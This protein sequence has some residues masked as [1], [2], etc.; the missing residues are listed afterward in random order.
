L[1]AI[2]ADDSALA[3]L[4]Q[5]DLIP[6]S[7]I[8]HLG[9]VPNEYCYYYYL[10]DQALERQLAARETRGQLLARLDGQL[11]QDLA[12]AGP[13]DADQLVACYGQY[14]KAREESYLAAERQTPRRLPE[15]SLRELILSGGQGYMEV[16]FKIIAGLGGLGNERAVLNVSNS[17]GVIPGMKEDDIVETMC[18]ITPDG[19]LPLPGP[20]LL[21]ES[22]ALLQ[23]VKAYERL[24][25]DAARTGS[26]WLAIRAL[27]H[28][29][30][31]A[32]YP[33]AE[34]LVDAYLLEHRAFLPQFWREGP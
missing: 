21:P 16:A 5:D 7:L 11:E 32:S 25:A 31:V 27:T 26:R 28:H 13:E 15:Q 22:L 10:R 9:A 1:P 6:P 12:Q 2:I 20:P 4:A 19:I 29:P 33:L 8:R 17:S 23:M 14:Y 18:E 24:T 30:L 34:K 3:R